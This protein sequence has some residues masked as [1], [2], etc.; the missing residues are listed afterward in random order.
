LHGLLREDLR[1][2][3]DEAGPGRL[4]ADRVGAS[5]ALLRELLLRRVRLPDAPSPGDAWVFLVGAL[6]AE[7]SSRGHDWDAVLV[8]G[9]VSQTGRAALSP[10]PVDLEALLRARSGAQLAAYDEARRVLRGE[11]T[12]VGAGGDSLAAATPAGAAVVEEAVLW[13]GALDSPRA[14]GSTAQPRERPAVDLVDV[15][16]G[17]VPAELGPREVA[18]LAVLRLGSLTSAEV[19]VSLREPDLDDVD[20]LLID[21]RDAGLVHG[22]WWPLV[23]RPRWPGVAAVVRPGRGA[24]GPGVGGGEVTTSAVSSD[25]QGST[26]VEGP[27]SA[28]RAQEDGR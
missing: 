3:V 8:A 2:V 1:R 19:G 20:V 6:R 25:E 7:V 22:A 28:L 17:Q 9:Q 27:A 4:D 16:R 12:D 26:A 13:G 23:P 14:A 24:R 11:V 21:L 10:G 18:V 15:A 5:V